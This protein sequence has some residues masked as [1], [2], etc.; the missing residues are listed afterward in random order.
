MKNIFVIVY[1]FLL[2]ISQFRLFC[3]DFKSSANFKGFSNHSHSLLKIDTVN[4]LNPTLKW[5]KTSNAQKYQIMIT[6]YENALDEESKTI[7]RTFEVTDTFFVVPDLILQDKKFYSWNVRSFDGRI[8]GKFGD[9][10][11]FKVLLKEKQIEKKPVT[12]SPGK[13]HPD[14]EIIK[15]LNPVFKWQKYIDADNYELVIFEEDIQG[16]KRKIFSTESLGLIKD[17]FLVL[18]G[19]L[20][21][22]NVNYCWQVRAAT[23]NQSTPFSEKRYFKIIIPKEVKVPEPIYPGF[24]IEDKEIIA[25]TT[26]TFVWKSIPSV[27]S[28]SIAISKKFPDGEYKL[29]YD[30]EKLFQIKDTVFTLSEGILENNSSY[31]WNIKAKLDD[32]RIVYSNRLYFK[33]VIFEPQKFELPQITS[34]KSENLEEILLTLEYSGVVKTFI[35]ALEYNDEI[36]ISID[37]FLSNLK[38]PYSILSNKIIESSSD[39]SQDY[40]LIDLNKMKAKNKNFEFDIKE[41]EWIEYYD[42]EYFSLSFVEKILSIKLEFDFSNLVLYVKSERALPIYNEYLLEQRLTSLKKINR[43]ETIPL[44]FSRKRSL[45]NGFIFDYNFSQT[46]VRNNRS[47]FNLTAA[48]GGELFYGD[49]YYSRQVFN[50]IN[51]QSVI[52]NFNWKFTPDP[53]KIL[54]QISIGDDFFD[55][56]NSYNYRGFSVTNEPIEPRKKIGTYMYRGISEPNSYVELYFNNEL[57]SITKADEKGNFSFELPINYGTSNYEFRIHTVKGETRSFRRIFQIP[58]DLI[59]E[60][61]FNYQITYGKLK[62]TEN[63]LA[64]VELKYGV[65]DFLTLNAG[66]EF[67]KVSDN[68]YLNFFGKSSFRLYPNLFLNMFYSPKIQTRI[69]ANYIRPDYASAYL[70]FINYKSNDFYNLPKFQ[71][72]FRG[73]IYFPIRMKTSELGVYFNYEAIKAESFK[74]DLWSFNSYLLFNTFSLSGNLSFENNRSGLLSKRRDFI[75]GSTINF[76]NIF[77]TVPILNRSFL[78]SK[79]TYEIL[80]K[81]IFS[82]SVF[83]TTALTKNLRFQINY[84]R[85]VQ[86]PIT[87]FN[88]NLFLELPQFRYLSNSNGK[89]LYNHQLSGS[90]GYSPEINQFYLYRESQIGRTALYIEGFEDKNGNGV[91]DREEKNIDGLDFIIN[92]ALYSENLKN[93]AKIF[94]GLN[95]YQEYSIVLNES[96]LKS[97]NYSYENSEF[98]ILM[99]GN[100][101]KVIQLPYYETGEIGGV[102]VRQF[103][104]EEILMSNVPIKIRNQNSGKELTISTFSDGSFYYYGLTKGK[105]EI[106]IDK[107]FLERFSVKSYPEK[108]E[109]EINPQINQLIIENLKF[110]LK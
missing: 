8:W 108:I 38:I 86:I 28:Y 66:S 82:Y 21:R 62:F 63:K 104:N 74:R 72:S 91:K 18:R 83:Y 80:R 51:T 37:D 81:K 29:I 46:L 92:S 84:E 7:I 43:E 39:N 110:I 69:T 2:W 5:F 33:V 99:D 40:F 50:A 106:T 100:T 6:E 49:F 41:N 10:F 52:E 34:D 24:K 48:I 54:T 94:Y 102:V 11:Y 64:N 26:P 67:I 3:N 35:Q 68:K 105:Y 85:I 25:T 60:G 77:R 103:E 19:N 1:L 15:T 14:F 4:T 57:I 59:P 88:L 89:N 44:L 30:S 23:T 95:S 55:G 96:N 70:E 87:N 31:R 71:N 93:N 12:F 109:I 90:I 73:N 32:G 53:N 76:N 17:T 22:P 65:K 107:N 101:L 45:L 78:S 61:T 56:I 47:N 97:L 20:L 9:E 27:E 42:Q 79:V 13:F 58:Y 98:K 36:Y 75:F 16:N